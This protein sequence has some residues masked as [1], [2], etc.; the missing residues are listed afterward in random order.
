MSRGRK[1]QRGSKLVAPWVLVV[2]GLS[3][4]TGCRT[5]E[6]NIERWANTQQGPTKLVAV[7]THDK[8]DLGLR[9]YAAMTLV[10]MR[11]RGGQRVGL[12]ALLEALAKLPPA[13]RTKLVAELVPAFVQR[14]GQPATGETDE[15]VPFKDAAYSL[16][17][18][19]GAPLIEDP[20]Q[21]AK[22]KE[23]LAGLRL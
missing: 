17:A 8:Y 23:A 20:A 12:D 4:N 13:E 16:I 6:E 22:L 5:S 14:L 9:T 2:L 11:P 3:A 10:G 1:T 18:D 21:Q 15:T 7:F 19:E